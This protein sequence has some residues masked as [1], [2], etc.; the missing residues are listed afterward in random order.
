MKALSLILLSA[1][2]AALPAQQRPQSFPLYPGT[3]PGEG[4]PRTERQLA[5]GG[6]VA[7][8]PVVRLTDTGRPSL[9][10]YRAP[11][12]GARPAVVVCPGGGYQLLAYDLEGE[13][14]CRWLNGLGLS[15]FLLKYRVPA[16][17]GRQRHEAPLQ[18]AQRALRLVRAHARE[19]GVDTARIGIMGFS[20][21]A[22]LSVMAS[23]HYADRAY[24]PVDAADSAAC[25]PAFC[26]LVYP[27][28]L[29]AGGLELSP[30]IRVGPDTPPAFI[31]QAED[32]GAFVDSSLAYYYALK[33]N[34]VP[35]RLVLYE[36][37]G[38]GFGLRPAGRPTDEWPERAADWLRD[39][40]LLP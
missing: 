5:E 34:G 15:A 31:V 16:L 35:A 2:C 12:E 10:F 37:G 36:S 1:V 18:D 22:H 38:H 23:T 29:S 33:Q 28:Y 8:Q 13:E 9:T 24:A 27:A 32:D 19:W 14:V 7:G 6:D 21:G 26:L 17:P 25:R 11:G 30:G 20:A 4:A 39:A 3:A 40:G